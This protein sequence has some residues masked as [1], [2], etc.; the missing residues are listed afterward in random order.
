MHPSSLHP[1]RT[2]QGKDYHCTYCESTQTN[3]HCSNRHGVSHHSTH[4][5]TRGVQ[6][7]RQNRVPLFNPL[8]V[9][10]HTVDN[11]AAEVERNDPL[12]LQMKRALLLSTLTLEQNRVQLL[13]SPALD[14]NSA[15]RK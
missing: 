15:R 9:Q 6:H 11:H 13:I 10:V 7:A 3:R 2:K 8:T 14:E 4:E 5:D 1:A 12:R